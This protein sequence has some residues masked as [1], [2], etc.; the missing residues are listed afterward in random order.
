MKH[1]SLYTLL[2]AVTICATA[3]ASDAKT[4]SDIYAGGMSAHNLKIVQHAIT[5]N[6]IQTFDKLPTTIRDDTH[7][8]AT[9]STVD[10]YGR[11]PTYGKMLYYGELNDDGTANIHGR[12]G[13]DLDT[14]T[15]PQMSELWFNGQ[16]YNSSLKFNDFISSAGTSLTLMMA[17][18]DGGRFDDQD[19]NLTWGLYG[20]YINTG[21]NQSNLNI[22]GNGGFVGLY[23]AHSVRGFDLSASI[24]AGMIYNN[25]EYQYTAADY[26]NAWLGLAVRATYTININSTFVLRPELYLGNTMIKTEKYKTTSDADIKITTL[27]STEFTPGLHAIKHVA[28]G[29]FGDLHARYVMTWTDGGDVRMNG[30]EMHELKSDDY[31]EYG[32]SIK[33]SIDKFSFSVDINRQDGGFTGWTFGGSLKYIF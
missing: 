29:W 30:V 19:D 7:V 32:L 33:K 1:I 13:G 18:L 26:A 14:N 2:T 3:S 24:D 28:D 8:S 11:F 6:A 15:T 27:T 12:N 17:G 25:A 20:G 16:Q 5:T 22:D 21:I 9:S 4:V 23:G 10:K 31:F